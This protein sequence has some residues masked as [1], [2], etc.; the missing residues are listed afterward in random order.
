[1]ARSRDSLLRCY[2]ATLTAATAVLAVLAASSG[3]AWADADSPSPA[4]SMTSQAGPIRIAA[5][6]GGIPGWTGDSAAE[7]S[8]Y[9][10][11]TDDDHVASTTRSVDLSDPSVPAGTPPALFQSER[12]AL[13]TTLA[14]D[15]PAPV[16]PATVRLYFA[17]N[18]RPAQVVGGRLMDV[19]INGA[20]VEHDLDVF[21]LVGGFKGLVR[22]YAVQSSGVVSIR[23]TNLRHKNS[24]HVMGAEVVPFD[25]ALAAPTSGAATPPVAAPP[26]V[27]SAP[28][29]GAVM[30]APGAD[31]AEAVSAAPAGTTFYLRNGV[32]HLGGIVPRD[33]DTIMG[34]SRDGTILDGGQIG[35]NAFTGSA[36]NVTLAALTVRNYVP[37][38]L[39]AAIDGTHTRNW[40]FSN[41]HVTNNADE[42]LA[43]GPGS[44][45]DNV[46][47]DHNG[48][49]G[50]GTGNVNNDPHAAPFADLAFTVQNSEL[51]FNGAGDSVDAAGAK[52]LFT[53]GATFTNNYVHDNFGFGLWTDAYN[54]NTVYENNRVVNNRAGGIFHEISFNA[55][56][57][58]NV[59]SGNAIGYC[60]GQT[61]FCGTGGISVSDS[62]D[63]QIYGNTLTANHDQI[64]AYNGHGSTSL[65]TNL[66]VHDNAMTDSVGTSGIQTVP[67]AAAA[68]ST[69]R[70]TNNRYKADQRFW[71]QGKQ[72][73]VS[74]WHDAGQN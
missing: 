28:P 23:I 27:P 59:I 65:L 67:Y 46:L 38:R 32:Y 57:R 11:S 4:P 62:G 3:L 69:S 9:L 60:S 35:H 66:Q 51:S 10:V 49:V 45:V 68:Y 30:L 73:N 24:A 70:W 18:F 6:S 64:V 44:L 29:A 36:S 31:V 39:F 43:V 42:G 52:V 26:V 63:V 20:T 50:L 34:Q 33:G 74:R 54:A 47:A 40:I 16:G 61:Y 71:W 72:I 17:E 8:Q 13:G 25:Q 48:N 2:K 19:A 5:G 37:S 15:I 58:D 56:I 53:N 14:Y 41:L 22:T 21:K 55:I 7:P 1:M 12:W